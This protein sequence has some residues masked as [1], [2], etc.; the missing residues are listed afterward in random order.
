MSLS[1]EDATW[2]VTVAVSL[3]IALTVLWPGQGWMTTAGRLSTAKLPTSTKWGVLVSALAM[4]WFAA[5][6]YAYERVTVENTIAYVPR[7]DLKNALPIQA[8]V[9]AGD[10]TIPIL[11]GWALA[12][13]LAAVAVVRA[14][15]L[16]SAGRV[17]AFATT[18]SVLLVYI[19]HT[20]ATGRDVPWLFIAMAVI[21][22]CDHR[23]DGEPLR[24]WVLRRRARPSAK[25]TDR[26]SPTVSDLQPSAQHRGRGR[27]LTTLGWTTGAL[28]LLLLFSGTLLYEVLFSE[29]R[30]DV[31]QTPLWIRLAIMAAALA[32]GSLLFGASAVLVKHGKRQLRRSIA[33]FDTLNGQRY[34]LYL[35]PF[36]VDAALATSPTEAPGWYTR[37]PFE[38]PGLTHEDFVIRQ[39]RDVGRIVAIGQPGE[40]LPEL[41]A[42]RGYVPL[43]DWQT[44]LSELIRGAHA[45]IMTASPGAGTVW[46]FTEAVRVS[47]P[48]RLLLLIYTESDYYTFRDAVEQEYANRSATEIGIW[49][50]LPPLPDI[51]SPDQHDKGMRWTF[52]LTWI[53][54]FDSD[55][56]AQFTRFPPTVPRLRHVW[57]IRRLI[58]RR[59][60]PILDHLSQLPERKSTT[61]H[62]AVDRQG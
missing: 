21:N 26:P 8:F 31:A 24:Q 4:A 5:L 17:L 56:R 22:G 60:A 57:T 35:R 18:T 27:L 15:V 13:N 32:V 9:F 49:P 37:S 53:F 6:N 62:A 14:S 11:S 41:G 38:L 29:A 39:F 47:V 34:L 61:T 30:G 50:P 25:R 33:S 10:L 46:E 51:P 7:G 23:G 42:E 48:A 16:V 40:R 43:D 19:S 3:Q 58:R 36:S 2:L 20:S 52:P 54:S 28:G 1:A 44:P 55:R 12:S 59:M 45:I